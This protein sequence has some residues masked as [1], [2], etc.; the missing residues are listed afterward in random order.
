[1]ITLNPH[2]SILIIPNPLETY[3]GSL[4]DSMVNTICQSVAFN[5]AAK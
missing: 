4:L 1:M 2:Q 5:R 3:H